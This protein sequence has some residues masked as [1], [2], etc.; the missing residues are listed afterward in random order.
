[1]SFLGRTSRRKPGLDV[2]VIRTR[3]DS[4]ERNAAVRSATTT[5]VDLV[6]GYS[7]V[8]HLAQFISP[9]SFQPLFKV[10]K[11]HELYRERCRFVELLKT[12]MRLYSENEQFSRIDVRAHSICEGLLTLCKEFSIFYSKVSV[13]IIQEHSVPV[14]QCSTLH[15]SMGLPGILGAYTC[16]EPGSRFV[17]SSMPNLLHTNAA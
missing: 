8:L 13:H 16:G 6:A 9:M 17:H 2:V 10:W 12:C 11:T 7:L 3:M 1:M 15:S 14:A 4:L 5:A